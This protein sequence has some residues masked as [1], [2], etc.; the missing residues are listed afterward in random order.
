[1]PHSIRTPRSRPPLRGR[2]IPIPIRIMQLLLRLNEF[3]K[4]SCQLPACRLLNILKSGEIKCLEFVRIAEVF[5]LMGFGSGERG[6]DV[7]CGGTLRTSFGEGGWGTVT[8]FFKLLVVV[9]VDAAGSVFRGAEDES[10]CGGNVTG[11][12]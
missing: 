1:M 12:P 3:D 5:W 10:A 7:L 4:R 9:D 8:V 2:H 6:K 11:V